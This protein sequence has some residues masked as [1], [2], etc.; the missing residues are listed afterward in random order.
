MMLL[1]KE[2]APRTRPLPGQGRSPD[3]AALARLLAAPRPHPNGALSRELTCQRNLLGGNVR[4]CMRA[5]LARGTYLQ[6]LD[7]GV[8]VIVVL[9]RRVMAAIM[10]SAC[11]RRLLLLPLYPGFASKFLW[12]TR[13][14]YRPSH[15]PLFLGN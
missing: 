3:D 2:A 15:S 5:W 14:S 4:A 6:T 12:L 10:Q 1:P 13:P 9:T 7:I 11:S 8:I